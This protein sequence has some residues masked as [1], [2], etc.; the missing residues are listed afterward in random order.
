MSRNLPYQHLSLDRSFLWFDVN[1]LL[2][3]FLYL[4]GEVPPSQRGTVSV[5]DDGPAVAEVQPLQTLHFAARTGQLADSEKLAVSHVELH[6]HPGEIFSLASNISA[7]T[8]L[9]IVVE[10]TDDEEIGENDGL[11]TSG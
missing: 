11:A 8:R 3:F 9:R 4:P 7:E 5:R 6:G 10:K 2:C 1:F